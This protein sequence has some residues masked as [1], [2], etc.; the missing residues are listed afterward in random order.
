MRICSNCGSENLDASY[1]CHHCNA[2]LQPSAPIALPRA[3]STTRRQKVLS[4][5]LGA[6]LGLIPAA[7]IALGGFAGQLYSGYLQPGWPFLG[8]LPFPVI[9]IMMGMCLRRK[10]LRPFGY[11]LLAAAIISPVVVGI[12]CAVFTYKA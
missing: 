2:L 12:S 4:F 9:L 10:A 7:I 1:R 11:G 3:A 6:A 5:V 8:C